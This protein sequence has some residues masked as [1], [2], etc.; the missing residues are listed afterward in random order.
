MTPSLYQTWSAQVRDL[1]DQRIRNVFGDLQVADPQVMWVEPGPQTQHITLQLNAMSVHFAFLEGSRQLLYGDD[2]EMRAF[3]EY[4]TFSRAA[5][6]RTGDAAQATRCQVCGAPLQP[7]ALVCAYCKNAVV[8]SATEWLISRMDE[9][10][11]WQD[12]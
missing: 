9:E 8:P 2:Q 12:G 5:G 10:L 11:I 7:G 4:W 3:T 1:Q 6:A